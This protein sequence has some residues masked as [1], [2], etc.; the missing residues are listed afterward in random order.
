M[1]RLSL[2]VGLLL[3]LAC[4][5]TA[6]AAPAARPTITQAGGARFPQRA[7]LLSVG[8]RGVLTPRQVSVTEGGLPVQ[9][10]VGRPSFEARA[11]AFRDRAV[12][13]YE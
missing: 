9:G 4:A 6:A 12:D 7:F 5:S 8:S 3:L 13:R 2:L 10:P 1:R 11:I